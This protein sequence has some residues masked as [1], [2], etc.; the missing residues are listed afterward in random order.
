[1]LHQEAGKYFMDLKY[2]KEET[3]KF[4]WTLA[5]F[6]TP[7]M[8]KEIN[9][10]SKK[11]WEQIVKAC[12]LNYPDPIKKW[13]D[14]DAKID[15]YRKKLDDLLINKMHV[16]GKDVDLWIKL[17]LKSAWKGG[18]G[19]N[20]PSF[21]IFTSP[22]WRGT[23]GWIKFSEPLYVYGN[24]VTGIELWFE[25]G[26]VIKSR[27]TKNYKVLKAMI[28]TENADKIGEF[29][30]TDNH[31]SEITEFMDET[32]FDENVGGKFGNTHVAL[33]RAYKD[34]YKGN[35]SKISSKQ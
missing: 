28:D 16:V 26:R 4:S 31:F 22:D 23:N 33:G 8:A 30:L 6:G 21:E 1:M 34:C 18:G 25:N 32:L 9:M 35:P 27:A 19:A 29:S 17:S 3:G 14:T 15:A 24:V 2:K 12:Y 13:R 20:I 11:Y 5:L 10:T 7:E